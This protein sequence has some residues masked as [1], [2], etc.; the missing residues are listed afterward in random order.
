MHNLC[1]EITKLTRNSKRAKEFFME[2]LAFTVSPSGLKEM[3]SD[4]LN[5]IKIFDVREYEEYLNGHIPYAIHIPV[6]EIKEHIEQ[7]D[8]EKL[9][10]VY[11][12]NP[13]CQR[14]TKVALFLA[15]KDYPVKVLLGGFKGWQKNDY[16]IIKNEE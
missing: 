13:I 7:F 9:N 15:E 10:I 14:G 8:K 16:E 12:H 5:D 11:G 1:E 4:N 6:T 3:L 2:H